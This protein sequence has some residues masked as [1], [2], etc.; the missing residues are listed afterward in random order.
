MGLVH[1]YLIMTRSIL[2]YSHKKSLRGIHQVVLTVCVHV[3]G[4]LLDF[5]LSCS[6]FFREIGSRKEV[7]NFTLL[8][9]MVSND[10]Q[11]LAE[12]RVWHFPPPASLPLCKSIHQD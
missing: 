9:I 8:R 6:I 2:V 12:A 3:Q 1:V 11:L 4:L 5:I 10:K 7:L